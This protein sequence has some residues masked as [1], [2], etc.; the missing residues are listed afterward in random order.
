[1]NNNLE[2]EIIKEEYRLGK[3]YYEVLIEKAK[4]ETTEEYK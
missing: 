4:E 3:E 2:E 1:M